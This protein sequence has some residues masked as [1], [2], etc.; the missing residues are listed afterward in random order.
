MKAFIITGNDYLSKIGTKH[1]AL[2][3]SPEVYLANFGNEDIL[4]ECDISLAETYLV[5]VWAGVRSKTTATTF[6]KLRVEQY[7]NGTGI[8]S[9]APTS[10]VIRGHIYRSFYLIRDTS[11]LLRDDYIRPDP[12]EN[13]WVSQFGRLLL[14]KNLKPLPENILKTCGCQKT[15]QKKN[16]QCKSNGNKCT[17]YCHG[18]KLSEVCKNR[19]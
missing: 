10:S 1:A 9:L 19:M 2:S 5:K 18:K 14:A 3:C 11:S 12:L 15:C 7:V 17:I 16:C 4:T 13:G 6:D 8:E